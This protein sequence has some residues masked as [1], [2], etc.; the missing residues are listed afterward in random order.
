[1]PQL[2]A[3]IDGVERLTRLVIGASNRQDLIDPASC[4]R[5][6]ST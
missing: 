4:G 6:G 5:A 1:V 2:L 3:E